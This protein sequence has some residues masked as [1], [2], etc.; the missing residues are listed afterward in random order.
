MP[1]A[2]LLQRGDNIPQDG[3]LIKIPFVQPLLDLLSSKPSSDFL[4]TTS[5]SDEIGEL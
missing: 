4:E 1:I 5:L 3:P 2:L